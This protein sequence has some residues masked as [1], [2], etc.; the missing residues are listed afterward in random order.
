MNV[1]PNLNTS[2]EKPFEINEN[3]INDPVLKA[4]KKFKYHSSNMIK[5]KK[6]PKQIIS[7]ETTSY[8]QIQKNQNL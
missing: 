3:K 7:F 1:V 6:N 2:S 4:I 8:K 5:H